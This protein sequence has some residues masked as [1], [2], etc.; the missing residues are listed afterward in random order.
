MAP[1]CLRRRARQYTPSTLPTSHSPQQQRSHVPHARTDGRARTALGDHR[2]HNRC[3]TC[4]G[5]ACAARAQLG[6]R[7]ELPRCPP[8][9]TRETPSDG[10]LRLTT[11][12]AVNHIFSGGATQGSRDTAGAGGSAAPSARKTETEGSAAAED[13]GDL[14]VRSG[15]PLGPRRISG[16]TTPRPRPGQAGLGVWD[17][18]V[19][20]FSFIASILTGTWYFFSESGRVQWRQW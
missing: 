10:G 16:T 7:G 5:R 13:L 15:V 14:A 4:T 17:T 8:G 11:Q 1:S 20:P 9:T 2:V 3:C 19:W 12:L 6:R 18:F